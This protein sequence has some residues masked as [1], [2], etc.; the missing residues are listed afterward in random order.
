MRVQSSLL[1]LCFLV[2]TPAL[3]AGK[4]TDILHLTLRTALEAQGG[5]N[6]EGEVSLKLRQQGGADV[7]KFRLEARN[8]DADAPYHVFVLLR[9]ATEPIEVPVAF[10]A[11]TNGAAALKRMHIGHKNNS[12]KTFPAG[13]D[14]LTDLLA[15]EIHDDAD[16]VV[17]AADLTDPDWLQYLVK[18]RLDAS[19]ADLDAEGT[20]FLKQHGAAAL[21]RLKAANLAPTADYTLA[22]NCVDV[23]TLDCAYVE[24]FTTDAN[25]RLDIGSLPGTPPA[26]FDM[27]QVFLLDA[28]D[29]VVL[30]TELP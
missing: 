29:Q 15:L 30:G 5:T 17:L 13:L 11:D 25:G 2:A 26:P 12:G 16:N 20:L 8:L 22:I 3:A 23:A 9:G 6:A 18:R 7:Q 1:A 4:G 28:A 10:D 19:G 24:T 14:P 27:T 21:F